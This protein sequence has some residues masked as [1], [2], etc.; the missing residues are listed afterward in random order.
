MVWSVLNKID[1]SIICFL[2]K[3]DRHRY[4]V[5]TLL[6][7]IYS[8]DVIISIYGISIFGFVE[9]NFFFQI[10]KNDITPFYMIPI[11]WLLFIPLSILA[12]HPSIYTNVPLL[13]LVFMETYAVVNNSILVIGA[14]FRW[15]RLDKSF[16]YVNYL[17]VNSQASCFIGAYLLIRLRWTSIGRS[18]TRGVS[19]PDWV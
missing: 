13:T 7:I 6:S 18:S 12:M 4:L 8:L 5:F 2:R 10:L 11:S 3:V 9:K 14:G 15:N 1:L 19:K 17:R 16:L